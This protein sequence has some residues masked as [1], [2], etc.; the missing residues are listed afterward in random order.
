MDT[1]LFD[2]PLFT[3]LPS[4]VQPQNSIPP[5]AKRSQNAED[6]NTGTLRSLDARF[7]E[8]IEREE[9]RL[10]ERTV[11]HYKHGYSVFRTFLIEGIRLAPSEFTKR[12]RDLDEYAVWHRNRGISPITVNTYWRVLG[13]FFRFLEEKHGFQNPY[14]THR[15][16]RFQA[17]PP[18]AL[19]SAECQRILVAAA[20][21]PKWT[22]FQRARAVALL[23][24]MLYAGLRRAE[25]IGLVNTDVDLAQGVIRVE[26]GKGPNGGK[27]RFVDINP[28]LHRILR[29]YLR[30]RD[31]IRAVA[32][33]FFTALNGKKPLSISAV[34]QIVL[35]VSKAA[36]V[37]FS[38]HKL[39]HSFV[40]HLLRAGV[41][42]QR[43]T[44][45][46][47]TLQHLHDSR[48]HAGV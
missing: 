8:Y 30:E 41:D 7:S 6:E 5:S 1:P 10:S 13:G 24:V 39:R 11:R 19:A 45:S 21:H 20:N 37:S 42:L 44:R 15:A 17:P 25:T 38:A 9:V 4:P 32:P 26:K 3:D 31:R 22:N 12:L 43:G 47:R 40:T 16:P 28:D 23:G 33:E 46:R 35:R 14:R 2:S 27:T 18:K 36:N 48:L 29:A 34:S